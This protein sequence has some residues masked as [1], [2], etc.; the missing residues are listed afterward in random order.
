MIEKLKVRQNARFNDGDI[1]CVIA[2]LN[3]VIDA[4]NENA[5]GVEDGED[6]KNATTKKSTTTRKAGNTKG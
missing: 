1:Y 6:K 5:A 3:E 4:V 2:K